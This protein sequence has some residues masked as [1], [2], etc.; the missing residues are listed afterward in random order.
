MLAELAQALAAP[1]RPVLQAQLDAVTKIQRIVGW[2]EID[3]YVMQQGRVCWDGVPC[4]ADTGE[5][6]LARARTVGNGISVQSELTCLNGHLF[7]I[8]S[9]MAVKHLAFRSDVQIQIY[10]LDRR[11]AATPG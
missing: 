7:C 4:F 10:E 5:F 1:H 8:E 11:Y 6:R 9:E 2:A 3:L